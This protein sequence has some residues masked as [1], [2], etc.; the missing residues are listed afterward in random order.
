VRLFWTL[1]FLLAA[2]SLSAT[3]DGPLFHSLLTVV[4]VRALAQDGSLEMGSGVVLSGG[5]LAVTCHVTRDA[6]RIE[7]IQGDRVLVA[8]SQTGSVNNDL[9]MLTVRGLEMSPAQIRHSVTLR[10]GQRV[11]AAGFPDG[12]DLVVTEGIVSGLHRAE[13]AWVIQ[14]T[15]PFTFGASGGALFDEAGQLTGILAFKARAGGALHFALPADW[16]L[17][18]SQVARRFGP[19]REQ[20][21]A[22]AFWE[23]PRNSQPGFLRAALL[24]AAGN[25]DGLAEWADRRLAQEPS[26]A[27]GWIAAGKAA[28]AT[29]ER[30]RALAAFSEAMRLEPDDPAAAFYLQAVTSGP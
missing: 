17:P 24:E 26:D 30:A 5:K 22:Q 27:G 10:P 19:L 29:G 9:C 2:W 1:G 7:V 4:K 25:L 14:T 12:G 8:E 21:R 13:G 11:F 28:A 6:W 20:S 18:G 15:A 16:L 3:A 23:L